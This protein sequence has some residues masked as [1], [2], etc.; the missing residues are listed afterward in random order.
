MLRIDDVSSACG[1]R[2]F[3]FVCFSTNAAF[4]SRSQITSKGSELPKKE[5]ETKLRSVVIFEINIF[6]ASLTMIVENVQVYYFN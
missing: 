3:F 4:G 6:L 5:S 2:C 1:F